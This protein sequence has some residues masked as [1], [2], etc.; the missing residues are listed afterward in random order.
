VNLISNQDENDT[1]SFTAEIAKKGVSDD[2]VNKG[3]RNEDSNTLLV[4]IA[5]TF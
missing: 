1:S 5:V 2:N 4:E 3:T